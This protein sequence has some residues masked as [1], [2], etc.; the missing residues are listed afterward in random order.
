MDHAPIK[1]PAS[2]NPLGWDFNES[3]SLPFRNNWKKEKKYNTE[4]LH[5]FFKLGFS[6]KTKYVGFSDIVTDTLNLEVLHLPTHMNNESVTYLKAAART[7]TIIMYQ[8][9]LFHTFSIKHCNTVTLSEKTK[10]F[11]P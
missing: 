6:F 3:C 8:W 1:K 11:L 2:K 10:G 4:K 9:L 7:F 5:S